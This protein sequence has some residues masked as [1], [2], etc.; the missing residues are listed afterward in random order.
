MGL[1]GCDGSRRKRKWDVLPGHHS[2]DGVLE[3]P[4]SIDVNLLAEIAQV[5]GF[6]DF[7]DRPDLKKG[8][9]E[10][11]RMAHKEVSWGLLTCDVSLTAGIVDDTRYLSPRPFDIENKCFLSSFLHTMKKKGDLDQ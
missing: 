7:S 9:T 5:D 11:I 6:R 1:D 2:V 4:V 3:V 10:G 8:K